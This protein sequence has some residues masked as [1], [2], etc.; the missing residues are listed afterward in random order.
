MRYYLPLADPRRQDVWTD[1]NNMWPTRLGTYTGTGYYASVATTAFPASPGTGLDAVV[2]QKTDG[3]TRLFVGTTTKIHEDVSGTW[4]DRS[5][6]GGYSNSGSNPWKFAQYGDISIAC[7][8]SDNPQSSTTGAFADLAGSPPKAAIPV[9]QSN[10]LLLFNVNDG[11]AKTNGWYSSDVGSI[12]TWTGGESANGIL[13]ETPGEI[14]AAVPFRGDVI[15]FK[16]SGVYRGTYVGL[17]IIWR[18]QLISAQYGCSDA[19]SALSLGDTV[20]FIAPYGDVYQFDGAVFKKISDGQTVTGPIVHYSQ[21]HAVC[22]GTAGNWAIYQLDTGQ[23]GKGAD[24]IS[25]GGVSLVAVI[26]EPQALI[27]KYSAATVAARRLI[28]VTA[29]STSTVYS[30][31]T[32]VNGASITGFSY[33][34]TTGLFGDNGKF[35]K[36]KRITPQ[37]LSM[38]GADKGPITTA[39]NLTCTM[40][41]YTSSDGAASSTPHTSIPASTDTKRFDLNAAARWAKFKIISVSYGFEIDDVV[42]DAAPAGRD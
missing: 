17:P 7:N 27:L 23:W 11:S 37:L 36:F 26:G 39:S 1:V 29:A 33:N 25:T 24:F 21:D 4:T 20:V 22:F 12:T 34:I 10:V 16:K 32:G 40:T 9:I 35:L 5:K 31:G 2:L 38:V 18:W 6:G 41:A 13:T 8:I 30:W 14:T 19:R 3:T 28:N 42:V 15:V